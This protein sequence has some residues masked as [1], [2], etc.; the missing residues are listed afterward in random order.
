M[1]EFA[2][3]HILAAMAFKIRYADGGTKE[4]GENDRYDFN[5]AGLLVVDTEEGRRILS[6]GEW[7]WIDDSHKPQSFAS[8]RPAGS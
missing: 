8:P 2:A 7:R 1:R 5:V 3:S 6:P 4:Y